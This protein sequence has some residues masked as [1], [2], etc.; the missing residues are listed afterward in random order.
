MKHKVRWGKKFVLV[1]L[2]L[3]V[4]VLSFVLMAL[5]PG[6]TAQPGPATGAPGEV[7]PPNG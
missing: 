2:V 3:A 7:P 1:R 6:V 4:L 5:P